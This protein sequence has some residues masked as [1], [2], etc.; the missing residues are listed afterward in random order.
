MNRRGFFG[1]IATLA[2]MPIVE[3]A[4]KFETLSID[5]ATF[6][7]WQSRGTLQSLSEKKYEALRLEMRRIYEAC[8]A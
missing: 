7:P 3:W 4:T 1:A 5:R 2:M 8:R 6:G